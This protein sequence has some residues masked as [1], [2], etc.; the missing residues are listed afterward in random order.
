MMGM[1]NVGRSDREYKQQ[2]EQEIETLK[3]RLAAEEKLSARQRE[4]ARTQA[5]HIAYITK[6]RDLLRDDLLTARGLLVII[7][8]WLDGNLP[9]ASAEQLRSQI[10]KELESHNHDD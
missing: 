9:E 6:D 10:T 2:Q 7:A 3:G 4:V 8:Q 1:D 5:F